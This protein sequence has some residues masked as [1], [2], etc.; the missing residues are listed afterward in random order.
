MKKVRDY[1]VLKATPHYG[2]TMYVLVVAAYVAGCQYYR[3]LKR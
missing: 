2:Y 1:N 3:C